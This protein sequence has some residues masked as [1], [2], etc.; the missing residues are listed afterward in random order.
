MKFDLGNFE[1]DTFSRPFAS[2]YTKPVLDKWL[3]GRV[4]QTN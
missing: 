2:P 3:V 4:S 1:L